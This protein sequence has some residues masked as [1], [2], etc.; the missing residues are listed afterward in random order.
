M[1]MLR[2]TIRDQ[3]TGTAEE[4]RLLACMHDLCNAIIVQACDDYRKAYLIQGKRAGETVREI[5]E[6]FHSRWFRDLTAIDPDELLDRLRADII[7][8]RKNKNQKGE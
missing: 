4:S 2:P 7:E 3:Q 8:N 1:K 6:F 5:E